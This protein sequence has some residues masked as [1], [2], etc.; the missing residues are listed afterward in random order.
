MAKT[1]AK[2]AMVLVDGHDYSA[3]S[4]S[5]NVQKATDP[6]DVTCFSDGAH[7]FIAGIQNSKIDVNFFWDSTATT[8]VN[9]ILSG[10]GTGNLSVIP[11]TPA[12]S[13]HCFS[14]PYRLANF[15]P[16]STP[17]DAIKVGTVGFIQDSI[18]AYPYGV[19]DGVVVAHGTIT[20]TTAS[21]VVD[22]G[23]LSGTTRN[24]SGILHIRTA[25]AADTYTFILEH[26]TTSGGSYATILTWTLDGTVLDSERKVAAVA[27]RDF[28][29]FTATRA[30]GSGQSL[31]YTAVFWHS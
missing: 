2:S 31:S 20:N 26:A 30:T 21:T 10:L 4:D 9:V 22:L 25:T 16:A 1:S 5:Y 13:G 8:G 3:Y 28:V 11:E 18:A 7:N 12:V 17:A 29:R 6:I 14:L 27:L 19:E 23:T 15:T 24:V